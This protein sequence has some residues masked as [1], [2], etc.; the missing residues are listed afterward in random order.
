MTG[1]AFPEVLVEMWHCHSRNDR[2]GVLNLYHR[3][4]PWLLFES[5][6][7]YSVAI[8]K[9]FLAGRHVL[10][11]PTVRRP[12]VPLEPTMEP[13]LAELLELFVPPAGE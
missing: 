7:T 3:Y 4:L 13:R 10:S 6:P 1:F 9:A 8:R 12:G 5:T 11:H 2:G